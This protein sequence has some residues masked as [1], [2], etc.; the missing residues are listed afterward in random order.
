MIREETFWFDFHES[1][2][3]KDGIY[4]EK[5]DSCVYFHWKSGISRGDSF[6]PENC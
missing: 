5:P 1:D 4:R 3:A 2:P 6:G